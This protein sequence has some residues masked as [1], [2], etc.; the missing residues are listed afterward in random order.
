MKTNENKSTPPLTP[1]SPRVQPYE[2]KSPSPYKPRKLTRRAGKGVNPAL[3]LL[4][5]PIDLPDIPIPAPNVADSSSGS[6]SALQP[7]N[8]PK[9]LPLPLPSPVVA[10]PDL[11][12]VPSVS[13][14]YS[15]PPVALSLSETERKIIE[16]I[17]ENSAAREEALQA[18]LLVLEEQIGSMERRYIGLKQKHTK[19]IKILQNNM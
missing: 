19:I 3:L 13:H 5:M 2:K 14:T 17:R 18:E 10:D 6:V 1:S 11:A 7:K 16:L 9:D 8:E 4:G 15:P 12:T